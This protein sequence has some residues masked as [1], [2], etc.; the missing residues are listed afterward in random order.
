MDKIHTIISIFI[1]I[2]VLFL[3]NMF[4]GNPL[5]ETFSAS[6]NGSELKEQ[7]TSFN[8]NSD[9]QPLHFSFPYKT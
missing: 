5:K 8:G 2:I 4:F 7:E 1:F 9:D 3:I 6:L